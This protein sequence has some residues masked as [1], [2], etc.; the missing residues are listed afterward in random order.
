MSLSMKDDVQGSLVGSEIH[1]FHTLQGTVV[2]VACLHVLI[3]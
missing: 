3:V 2:I 1:G